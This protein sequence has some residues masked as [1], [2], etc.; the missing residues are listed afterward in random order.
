M[1]EGFSVSACIVYCLDQPK[2]SSKEHETSS[3][4]YTLEEVNDYRNMQAA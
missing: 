2:V 4:V 1:A 3:R